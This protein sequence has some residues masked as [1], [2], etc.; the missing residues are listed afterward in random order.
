[1]HESVV[2]IHATVGGGRAH[3]GP[4][5]YETPEHR[6]RGRLAGHRP[7]RLDVEM[8]P[9][10]HHSRAMGMVF[11]VGTLDPEQPIGRRQHI[12]ARLGERVEDGEVVAPGRHHDIGRDVG[13][14]PRR[15][16]ILGLSVEFVLFGAADHDGHR[17]A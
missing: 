5:E 8:N 1:M 6:Y 14:A 9:G 7:H 13:F 10:S 2:S 4:G 12:V 15:G 3:F 17:R 11:S 16:K